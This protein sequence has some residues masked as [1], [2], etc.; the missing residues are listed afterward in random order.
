M[1]PVDRITKARKLP[2]QAGEAKTENANNGKTAKGGAVA[3]Q[4]A[5]TPATKPE[6][7][8]KNALKVTIAPGDDVDVA[9][10]KAR[11]H[12]VTSATATIRG[13]EKP[14]TEN[15]FASLV[16]E[17]SRHVEDVK[18]GNMNR[19]E[20]ILIM[21]AQTLD[22]IFHT[23]AQRAAANVG[24][25]RDTAELYL[26]MA[27]KAQSQCRS[28]LETLA[29]IKA[30][31]S[32]NF[33]RQQNVAHQQQ[34]NNANQQ[35]V[36]NGDPPDK[37]ATP[38]RAHGKNMHPKQENEQLVENNDGST[39]MDNGTTATAGRSDPLLETVGAVDRPADSRGEKAQ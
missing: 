23:M 35:Q 5:Q 4:A 33:I 12:P 21:Q 27:L 18:A 17:L 14:M 11:L 25:Y 30:P 1:K 28:T 39:Q 7:A 10:V 20:T 3:S 31:R 13:F 9:I 32:T 26:R 38:T 6:A 37:D 16:T 29:E 2:K 22:V 15:G 24:T 34:V 19:P 8:N 36:N